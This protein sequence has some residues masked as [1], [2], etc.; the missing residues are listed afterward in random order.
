MLGLCLL[1]TCP[2]TYVSLLQSFLPARTR[3]PSAHRH[4]NTAQ[5]Y[6]PI[7]QFIACLCVWFVHIGTHMRVHAYDVLRLRVHACTCTYPH[8]DAWLLHG[9]WSP[10]AW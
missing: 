5:H 2:E 4:T 8:G 3:Q 7:H 1:L 6:T 10:V 9:C